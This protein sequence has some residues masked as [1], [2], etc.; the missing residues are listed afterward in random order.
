M[1]VKYREL[2]RNRRVTFC[3]KGSG[4]IKFGENP[5]NQKVT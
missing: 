2:H 5:E 3:Y 1:Q 4:G